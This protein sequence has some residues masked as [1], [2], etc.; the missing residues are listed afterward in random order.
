M[1]NERRRANAGLSRLR[2]LAATLILAATCFCSTAGIAA[3]FLANRAD[4]RSRRGG[5]CFPLRRSAAHSLHH[6]RREHAEPRP[7][8]PNGETLIFTQYTDGYDGATGGVLKMPAAG[9]AARA[10]WDE[11]DATNVNGLASWN[12]LTDRVAFAVSTGNGNIATVA[13]TGGAGTYRQ[14]TANASPNRA[15]LEPTF[16]A[17]GET[18]AFESDAPNANSDDDTQ[19]SLYLVAARGGAPTP[20]VTEGDN[21]LP[22]YSPD[23][24]LILF[25]RRT[26]LTADFHLFTIDPAT[27][28]ITQ[29]T[30]IAGTVTAGDNC[31]SDAAWSPGGHWILDSACYGATAEVNIFLVSPDGR[32][33]VRVTFND[34]SEDGAPAMSPDGD[35]IYFESHRTNNDASPSQI[36]ASGNA[37]AAGR[38][39][40]SLSAGVAE[41]RAESVLFAHRLGAGVHDLPF[42]LQRGGRGIVD[43]AVDRRQADSR[44]RQARPRRC[45]NIPG[46]CWSAKAGRIA[47]STDFNAVDGDEIWTVEP[48]GTFPM[49]VTSHA[50]SDLYLEP[51]YSP[52]GTLIV[53]EKDLNVAIDDNQRASLMIVKADGSSAPTVLVDGPQSHTDNREPNWSPAGGRIVFQR[54]APGGQFQL[55]TIAPNGTAL[56]RLT[57]QPADNTDPRWSPDGGAVVYSSDFNPNDPNA[58]LASANLFVIP[59]SGGT[60]IRLTNQRYYDGAPSWSP[61]GRWIRVR[62]G[63]GRPGD[64]R[65]ETD[66]RLDNR[67]ANEADRG[68]RRRI[69]ARPAVI[70]GAASA[71]DFCVVP[72]CRDGG[73]RSARN[74]SGITGE[75]GRTAGGAVHVHRDSALQHKKRA[76]HGLPRRAHERRQRSQLV[77]DHGDRI[78]I[79][80]G[81]T[82]AAPRSH[83]PAAAR[84]RNPRMSEISSD[85]RFGSGRAGANW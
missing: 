23:G 22:V 29:I 67:R 3:T 80:A 78:G 28:K 72:I 44:V 64:R 53:F 11:F 9:G 14:I 54:R 76:I 62:D 66:E 57:D 4:A 63:C 33:L 56:A 55:F 71:R 35:W 60:P 40:T 27:K 73:R 51:S 13:P 75:P 18:V 70:L 81:E 79:R 47:F 1:R 52:D 49:R 20:L 50:T 38:L 5:D 15:F 84:T 82:I 85:R 19:G 58:P 41:R 59:A 83:Q 68:A 65:S 16:S 43:A 30:G 21:R 25:Q 45:M 12:G 46:S 74:P 24:K 77:G 6:G 26:D 69:A 7:L 37:A 32:R 42:V 31:D 2:F 34:A 8:S 17:N 10:L 36:R 61:G 39:R 48:N